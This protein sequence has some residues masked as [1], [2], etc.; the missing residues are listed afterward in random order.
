M[1]FYFSQNRDVEATTVKEDN[2]GGIRLANNPSTAPNRNH[3]DARHPLGLERVHKGDYSI[4][5]VP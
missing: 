4:I 2:K 1:Q 3:I 5:Q